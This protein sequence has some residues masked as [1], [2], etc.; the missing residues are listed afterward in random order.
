MRI[1]RWYG[2]GRVL[3]S[4]TRVHEEGARRTAS[5]TVWIVAQGRLKKCHLHQL[6]HS[7]ERERL[8][9]E[10]SPAATMPWTL[11]VLEG[12]IQKGAYDDISIDFPATK[13]ANK[14]QRKALRS[15]TPVPMLR[16]KKVEKATA[17]TT[18]EPTTWTPT[19]AENRR[20]LR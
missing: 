3:A 13:N 6:R 10:Q 17:S 5:S 9:A 15:R 20:S 1:S 11:N 7:S 2:P 4:E 12:L 18:Q 14:Q 19:P 16:E 8:M